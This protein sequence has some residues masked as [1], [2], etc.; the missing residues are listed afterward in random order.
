MFY[1]KGNHKQ[2][3]K[4]IYW[5]GENIFQGCCQ[6]GIHFQNIQA[7]QYWKKEKQ[8]EDSINISPNRHT[9]SQQAHEKMFNIANYVKSPT[10]EWFPF[11]LHVCKSNFFISP[12]KLA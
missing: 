3:E 8:E 9:D 11:Q 10:V 6:Q 2:N 5:L 12:I 7:V 4:T 1:N